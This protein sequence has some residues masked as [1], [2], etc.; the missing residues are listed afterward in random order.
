[1]A[2]YEDNV[3]HNQIRRKE[4]ITCFITGDMQA[5][6]FSSAGRIKRISREGARSDSKVAKRFLINVLFFAP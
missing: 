6:V 5:Y 2:I 3:T 1:V 4:R